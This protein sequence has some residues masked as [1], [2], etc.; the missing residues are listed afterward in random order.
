MKKKL[1]IGLLTGA[2]LLG[3]AST[4]AFAQTNNDVNGNGL[5]NFG[6]MK[7]YMEKM[8]PDLSNQELKQMYDSC[9]SNG[10]M[11]ENVD[12]ADMMPSGTTSGMMDRF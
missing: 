8:H 10:G 7:P 11:M 5:F 4:M 3:G 6:Q 2:I 1:A 12:P 9:H